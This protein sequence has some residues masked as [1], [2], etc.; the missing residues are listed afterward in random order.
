M[1]VET[2]RRG[3]KKRRGGEE[4]KE[5]MINQR[6]VN[7]Q[8]MRMLQEDRDHAKERTTGYVHS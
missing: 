8:S 1:S 7:R 6:L 2:K 4:Q 3:I 5:K